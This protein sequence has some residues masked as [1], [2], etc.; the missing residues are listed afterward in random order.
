LEEPVPPTMARG[1]HRSGVTDGRRWT[2]SAEPLALP[3]ALPAPAPTAGA[4]ANPIAGA[5]PAPA[6]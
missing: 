1:G 3:A 4:T 6:T 5:N 2:V